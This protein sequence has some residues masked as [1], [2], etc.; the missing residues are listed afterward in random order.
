M[1]NTKELAAYLEIHEK[2]VYALIKEGR[3]PCTKA[4]GKWIFPRNLIDE[5]I[6]SSARSSIANA[7]NKT[8][9]MGEALLAAGSN[10]PA[11][12]LLFVLFRE[13]RPKS[14]IFT[15]STGSSQGLDALSRGYVDLAFS[16][17]F[18][19]ETGEYN[20]PFVAKMS[21]QVKP[22]VINLFLRDIGIVT[23]PKNPHRIRTV[24]DIVKK[25]LKVANRQP[26]SGTRVL[27]EH[28]LKLAGQD[29]KSV[30]S[31]DREFHTHIETGLAVLSGQADAGIA[32]GSAAGML[33]LPFIPLATEQFDMVITRNSFFSNNVQALMETLTGEQFRK[34]ASRLGGYDFSRSGKIVY[35]NEH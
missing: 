17:L 7:R 25:R 6:D 5:W 29:I 8:D 21:P 1:M 11:L 35:A 23:A 33:G 30:K 20:I 12:D 19:A 24:A 2:Q 28:H 18:D 27:F 32:S 22:V 4:T 34:A 14:F 9:R 16:H 15:A 10:D 3:I 31:L 13:N 26:G